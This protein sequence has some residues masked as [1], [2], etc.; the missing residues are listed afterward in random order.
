MSDN[1]INSQPEE[2]SENVIS[3]YYEGVKD[4]EM[5]GYESG[6]KKARNALF[7]TAALVFI[8]ELV[9]VSMQ[10]MEITP[11][12]IGIALLE[13]GL[14]VALAFWTKTKPLAAIITG[15]I[16][17]VIL[18]GITIALSDAS[19]IYKGIIIKVIIIVTLVTAIKP[20][21]AWEDLKKSK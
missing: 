1:Q 4:L 11:L 19:A 2:K 14:F 15:L 17:F 7:V 6:I 3:D 16:L 9:G 18:W 20:A 21:K 8:S 5:Q 13:G 10:G 12:V